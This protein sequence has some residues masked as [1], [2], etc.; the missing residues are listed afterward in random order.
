M[1][2]WGSNA[3]EIIKCLLI[4]NGNGKE[5]LMLLR[6]DEDDNDKIKLNF[7]MSNG[8]HYSLLNSILRDEFLFPFLS[9]W[10]GILPK[11]I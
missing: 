1:K 4:L 2:N 6:Q 7:A 11:Y 5:D 8:E 3:L 9:G 10:E